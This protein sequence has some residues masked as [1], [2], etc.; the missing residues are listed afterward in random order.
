MI[1]QLLSSGR[2]RDGAFILRSSESSIKSIFFWFVNAKTCLAT[3]KEVMWR[4]P[5]E[6]HWKSKI[7]SKIPVESWKTASKSSP[8][9]PISTLLHAF[10]HSN[11]AARQS[12]IV[13]NHLSMPIRMKDGI[14]WPPLS[15]P[16]PPS[17]SPPG[18]L[19][20]DK[21]PRAALR[22]LVTIETRGP[23][24]QPTTSPSGPFLGGGQ[25]HIGPA[26]LNARLPQQIGQFT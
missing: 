4:A 10:C 22:R 12:F 21:P 6:I 1:Y 24:W 16:A 25:G 9:L 23:K 5:W 8:S 19:L 7:L 2:W 11:M 15:S 14:S 18:P 20:S 17:H 3:E 13:P 26:N